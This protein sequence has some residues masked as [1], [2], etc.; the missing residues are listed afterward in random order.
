IVD[1]ACAAD[2]A[3]RPRDGD[4]LA[5]E[6]EGWIAKRGTKPRRSRLALAA[7]AAS[8][9][10]LL[11][12]AALLVAR[13]PAPPAPPS[14]AAPP[15]APPRP[16][17]PPPPRDP[18]APPPVED[19]LASDA[20]LEAL[21][22]R[23]HRALTGAERPSDVVAAARELARQAPRDPRPRVYVAFEKA[24]VE[25]GELDLRREL[26][27]L[28][29]SSPKPMPPEGLA[30]ASI[31]F[32]TTGFE[33]AACCLGEDSEPDDERR[34]LMVTNFQMH[35][36]LLGDDPVRDA[37]RADRLADIILLKKSASRVEAYPQRTLLWMAKSS[38]AV[39]EGD[40]PRAMKWLEE[41]VLG[42]PTYA[43]VAR[44]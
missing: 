28:L 31:F 21:D 22:E 27:A 32:R 14:I 41:A 43:P 20:A 30:M 18:P 42:D 19:G 2:P 15:P 35:F 26:V 24:S 1:R 29:R 9:A 40:G 13:R 8:L 17:A 44:D 36:H 34:P 4:A 37:T 5:A 7:L 16:P 6:L 10:V 11:A 25:G 33:R 38:A 23:F 39:G 12:G 3:Q